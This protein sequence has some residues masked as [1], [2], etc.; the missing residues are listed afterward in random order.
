VKAEDKRMMRLGLVQDA[1]VQGDFEKTLAQMEQYAARAG[2]QDG[3]VDLL[4]FPELYVTGYH[5]RL[6]DRRPTPDDELA[7]INCMQ[8]AADREG[9]WIVFGHPSYR[10]MTRENGKSR[11][12]QAIEGSGA[13]LPLYNAISLVS[14]KGLCET[15]AKVHLYGSE[16]DSFVPGDVFPV[17]TTPWGKVGAQIC[18]DV[19]FPEGSRLEGLA[20]ADLLL[21]P[22][23]NFVPYGEWHRIFTAARGLEN[24]AFAA[25]V[26]RTGIELSTEFCGGSC[27]LHPNGTWL[28]EASSKPG[29]YTCDIVFSERLKVDE[30]ND[31]F[32][33]RRPD[34]YSGISL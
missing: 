21:F 24:R 17:W 20:G 19:E 25:T 8:E 12:G 9:L 31:Y 32:R 6:W 11:Y 33:F 34:L 29:L 14:P 4:V 10:A 3:K 13:D 26:N 5:S 28:I 15:Y 23:N 27:V 2:K 30:S 18:F 16:W 22:A 7:W 1:P